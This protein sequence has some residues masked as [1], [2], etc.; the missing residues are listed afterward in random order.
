[1]AMRQSQPQGLGHC[2]ACTT[3]SKLVRAFKQVV[4][5][6]AVLVVVVA[7]KAA[8][9]AVDPRAFHAKTVSCDALLRPEL[10]SNKIQLSYV[11]VNPDADKTLLMVHGW[12]SLWHSWKYQI[13]EFRDDYRLV[14][15]NLR[16]FGES[17]YPGDVQSS[18]TMEDLVNDLVCVLGHAGASK[19][20]C[21]GHDWG[22]Q[23]CY[24][25]AR[26]RPDI[27]E[28]VIGTCIPYLP[29]Q[30]P[31]LASETL[32]E[33]LPKVAYTVFIEKMTDEAAAELGRD[34]RRTLRATLRTVD[35]AP[36]DSF[37]LHQDSFLRGWIDVDDIPPIPFLTPDE[38]DY[39]VEQYEKGRFA[40]TLYFYTYPN[41]YGSWETANRQGN[42]IIS[43]PVLSI[44][45]THDPVADWVTAAQLLN[46]QQFIENLTTKTVR[47]AHWL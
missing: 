2:V 39:W 26:M 7:G 35:S 11:D 10:E 29:Y 5:I 44:L 42:H 22:T 23:I 8:P 27:F 41:R 17:T 38:E 32:A 3:M 13:E 1:M 18:S 47:A 20:A 14:V 31:F 9:H 15:P 21:V 28:A 19:A 46:S 6:V 36:P 30:G 4:G 40:H 43:A 12:P 34:V 37:L 24:E 45:P 33:A 25:A 16:G